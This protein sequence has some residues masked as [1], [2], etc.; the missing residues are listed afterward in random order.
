MMTAP[1]LPK[2]VRYVILDTFYTY[3]YQ[4][5]RKPKRWKRYSQH[6]S[7][8]HQNNDPKKTAGLGK[9]VVSLSCLRGYLNRHFCIKALNCLLLSRW[10]DASVVRLCFPPMNGRHRLFS[11]PSGDAVSPPRRALRAPLSSVWWTT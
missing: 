1:Q 10:V 7:I 6:Y 4:G 11:R 8:Q 9:K 2:P 5:S 3:I